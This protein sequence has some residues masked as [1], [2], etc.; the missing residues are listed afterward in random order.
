LSLTD[1]MKALL[2]TIQQEINVY[3]LVIRHPRT[4]WHAR[5]VLG[6]AI[7]YFLSPID[8]IPD[9]IPVLGQ[10]DDLLIVPGLVTLAL[11]LIP[12]E[13]V[14]EC[15]EQVKRQKTQISQELQ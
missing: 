4:P 2:N 1:R 10:L 6:L 3:Q 8:L 9:P 12:K 5:I 13:V 14:A 15:R 7:A 11:K